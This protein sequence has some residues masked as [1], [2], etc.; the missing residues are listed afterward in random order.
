MKKNGVTLPM[1]IFIAVLCFSVLSSPTT[2]SGNDGGPD[3]VVG[4][5]PELYGQTGGSTFEI[6]AN[7]ERGGS[8]TPSASN[9]AEGSTV[10]FTISPY[11]GYE[12][13]S[14]AAI[15]AAGVRLEVGCAEDGSYY[16]VMP[17]ENVVIDVSFQYLREA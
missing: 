15:T 5:L 12:T 8:V 6:T 9:G 7:A 14:I 10:S 17:S 16:F 4:A 3:A 1:L 13:A 2:A 11:G